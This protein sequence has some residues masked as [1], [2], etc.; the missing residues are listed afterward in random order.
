[1]REGGAGSCGTAFR[2]CSWGEQGVAH[3][4]AVQAAAGSEGEYEADAARQRL[5]LRHA[6]GGDDVAARLAVRPGVALEEVDLPLVE[7]GQ[8]LQLASLAALELLGAQP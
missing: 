4:A 1:L 2:C 7:A 5:T 8:R 6:G 3:Q